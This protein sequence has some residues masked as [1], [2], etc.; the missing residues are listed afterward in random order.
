MERKFETN[1]NFG[2]PKG[3]E[4]TFLLKDIPLS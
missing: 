2:G 3:V 1:E 4:K